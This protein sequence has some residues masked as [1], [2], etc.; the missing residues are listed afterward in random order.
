[1]SDNTVFT[2]QLWVLCIAEAM[3]LTTTINIYLSFF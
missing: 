3:V 2:I 1:M